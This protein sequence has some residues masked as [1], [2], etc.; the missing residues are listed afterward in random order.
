MTANWKKEEFLK[1]L[2]SIFETNKVPTKEEILTDYELTAT[3]YD[4][5]LIGKEPRILCENSDEECFKNIQKVLDKVIPD[6]KFRNYSITHRAS[7]KFGL[8]VELTEEEYEAV[9]K[10]FN[11]K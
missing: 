7:T 8:T 6:W 11:E 5:F 3:D 4:N 9:D 10:A 1:V 2:R